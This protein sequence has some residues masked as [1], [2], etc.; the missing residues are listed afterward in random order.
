[1]YTAKMTYVNFTIHYKPIC[2][3]QF[4]TAGR[5]R[6]GSINVMIHLR[7]ASTTMLILN[8]Y[9][10]FINI[11]TKESSRIDLIISLTAYEIT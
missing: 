9:S 2:A 10:D 3:R 11:C 6:K 4:P 7:N 1:M 5:E 8:D